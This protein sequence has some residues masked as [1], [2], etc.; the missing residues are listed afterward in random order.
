MFIRLLIKSGGALNGGRRRAFLVSFYIHRVAITLS[1]GI[2]RL[3]K[4]ILSN[5]IFRTF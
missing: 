4:A 5:S 1:L 2:L 3:K